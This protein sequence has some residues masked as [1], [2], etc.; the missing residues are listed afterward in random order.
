M[1]QICP[2]GIICLHTVRFFSI[3][4]THLVC[5]RCTHRKPIS[6]NF[7]LPGCILNYRPI[8]KIQSNDTIVWK[9]SP[10]FEEKIVHIIIEWWCSARFFAKNCMGYYT[11]W[12]WD[13]CY[14][15]NWIW[16]IH[17]SENGIRDI[18]PPPSRALLIYPPL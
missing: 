5:K 18:G 10:L 2:Y 17:I 8:S 6:E 13:I 3:S 9:K 16:D 1:V 15:E 12:N 11:L 14:F 7:A 4:S